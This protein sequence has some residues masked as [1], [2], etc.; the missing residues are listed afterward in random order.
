[1]SPLAEVAPADHTGIC[2]NDVDAPHFFPNLTV[3]AVEIGR[4]G[5][6]TLNRRRTRTEKGGGCFELCLPAARDVNARAFFHENV[7]RRQADPRAR[8]AF[9]SAH[10]AFRRFQT[11][12][13]H[14]LCRRD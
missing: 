12:N 7:S 13:L 9:T 10:I 11:T 1:M 5:D 6:I 8:S 2:E 4:L 14:G 3:E